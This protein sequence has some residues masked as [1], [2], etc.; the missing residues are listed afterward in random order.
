[1]AD[2]GVHDQTRRSGPDAT[3]DRP[4]PAAPSIPPARAM[5]RRPRTRRRRRPAARHPTDRAARAARSA[6]RR[7]AA[8]A[9]AAS[10]RVG[11]LVVGGPAVHR[12]LRDTGLSVG[13]TTCSI[14]K[15]ARSTMPRETLRDN[16]SSSP[17]SSVVASCGRSASSG[18]STWVVCAERRRRP[19]PRHR[20]PGRQERRRQDLDVAGQRQRLADR[21]ATALHGR[22]PAAGRGRRAAPTE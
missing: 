20:S 16:A 22:E 14:A 21:A 18:L 13:S 2:P 3:A 11:D 6:P 19:D 7:H 15:S 1:M 12:E 10:R 5:R 4:R 8:A 17:G 9:A